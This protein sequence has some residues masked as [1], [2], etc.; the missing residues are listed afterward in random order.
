M[1]ITIKSKEDTDKI[2]QAFATKVEGY[3]NIQLSFGK[4]K[5]YKLCEVVSKQ[6]DYLLWLLGSLEEDKKTKTPTLKAIMTYI[7]FKLEDK[8]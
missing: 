3:G 6:P 4:F 7:R 5:G 8:D 1:N 2:N